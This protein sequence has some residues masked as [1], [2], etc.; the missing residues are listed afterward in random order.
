MLHYL[1]AAKARVEGGDQAPTHATEAIAYT[2]DRLEEAVGHAHAGED[3]PADA[4]MRPV[5]QA[6]LAGLRPVTSHQ[7]PFNLQLLAAVD[8]IAGAVDQLS[9]L[10]DVQE[11][12]STRIQASLATTDLTLDDVVEGVRR[13]ST[14]VALALAELRAGFA[15]VSA[16]Q[17]RELAAM[18]SEIATMRVKQDLISRTAREALAGQ[19]IEVDQLTELSRRLSTGYEE[20]YEDLE[21]TFRGTRDDVKAKLSPYLPDVT[22]APGDGSVI[23]V[24]CGRGEWL[25]LLGEQGI[26]AYGVDVNEVVVQ[27]CVARGLDV[28]VGDALVHL[29]EIPEGSARAI[30]SFHV[31]EHLDLD[32]LVGL[33]DAALVAL[34][35]GGVLVFETPNPT[36][37]LVGAASFYLDP[38]HLKPLHPQFLD[39]LLQARGFADVEVRYLNRPTDPELEPADLAGDADPD[40]N[41]AVVDRINWALSGPLDYGVV[42]RKA[43]ASSAAG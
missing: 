10:V 23:D 35:P 16:T 26:E 12:R 43:L 7:H 27:R 25:E 9:Q 28:R 6:V 22:A 5:K 11:H 1:E 2:R 32:T 40:R 37:V 34:A 29:R 18:R 38:T 39:F 4:R 15:E 41:R 3:L 24:G 19:G 30:T 13:L 17:D 31:V 33:I 42:A 20:L 8:G 21:D 36:N 14:D